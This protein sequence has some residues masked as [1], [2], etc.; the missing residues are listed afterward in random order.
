MIVTARLLKL[1]VPGVFVK[2]GVKVSAHH[3]ILE[4][5]V[6]VNGECCKQ[7]RT[8]LN[9]GDVVS[10]K[11]QDPVSSDVLIAWHGSK[12][13]ADKLGEEGKNISQRS[14]DVGKRKGRMMPV[15]EEGNH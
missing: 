6:F 7:G 3:A 11:L 13:V 10:L 4:G 1:S 9:P 14:R 12:A 8:A 2:N 15:L 5:V